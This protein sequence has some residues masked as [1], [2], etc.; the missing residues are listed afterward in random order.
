MKMFRKSGFYNGHVES[1]HTS[2]L[3][4]RGG[5]RGTRIDLVL[6]KNA[7]RTNPPQKTS[8]AST[9]CARSFSQ[10]NTNDLILFRKSVHFDKRH[11]SNYASTIRATGVKGGERAD[12][13]LS[14]SRV[15]Y[16][17]PVECER[18]QGIP[19]NYT[20]VPYTNGAGKA[21]AEED[22]PIPQRNKAIG[23]SISVP[24]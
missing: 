18:L 8:S 16:L 21:K 11:E 20:R 4:A 23:N 17:T 22:C 10:Q 6:Y 13:V 9:I 1:N 2:A 3:K 14:E 24:V 7:R 19:D 12:L 5:R 15:R